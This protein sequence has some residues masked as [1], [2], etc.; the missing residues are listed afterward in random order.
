MLEKIKKII[1]HKAAIGLIFFVIGIGATLFFQNFEFKAKQQK[2]PIDTLFSQKRGLDKT[3]DRVFD[4]D[5]FSSSGDPF[6]QMKKM[7]KNMLKRFE[8]FEDDSGSGLFDSWFKKR[9][10]GGQPGDIQTREDDKFV[11]YDVFVKGLSKE[12]VDIRVEDG[13]ITVSGTVRNE[14]NDESEGT[15]SSFFSSSTFHRSFPVPPNVDSGKVQMEQQGDKIVV[16]FPK[17]T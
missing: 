13:Q 17:V 9:F 3:F 7:R 4:D 6:S 11:Y 5:F 15:A 14:S 12:K 2:D 8:S 1:F 16:K 10:G